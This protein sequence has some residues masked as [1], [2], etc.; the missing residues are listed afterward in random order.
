[1]DIKDF[2]GQKT[3]VAM[4]MF[5]GVHTGHR[6]VFAG[7]ESF[8]KQGLKAAVFTFDTESLGSKHGRSYRYILRN[9]VKLEMIR[10]AGI[11]NIYCADFSELKDYDAE[12][13]V[14]FVL[15][16]K[17]NAGAVVCGPDF[18]FGRGAQCGVDDLKKFGLEYGFEVSIV[19]PVKNDND[20]IS[21][22]EIR[23]LLSAG[24][25]KK[26]NEF[27]GY[28]YMIKQPVINGKHI[29]RT[30]DFPTV[31]Q[32][33]SSGQLIPAYGVYAA[34]TVIDGKKYSAVTNIGVKPTVTDECIP[35][36]ETHIIGYSGDLYGRTVEISLS[37]YLRGE[38]KFGSLDELKEQIR[39]DTETA[40]A[41]GGI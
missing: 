11:E 6:A 29:G 38:K 17:M 8:E 40:K 32:S 16:E 7:A 33:F 35:L 37:D 4:G 27:L 25:I 26:A 24:N 2:S 13:F 39:K 12:D 15:E 18:R 31:N 1:M 28:N 21:S 5:D 20:I 30:I 23:E 14:K 19:S 9:S 34:L 22:S 10:K 3:A 41:L 36:A